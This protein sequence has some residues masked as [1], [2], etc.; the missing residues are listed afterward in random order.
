[1]EN[2]GIWN[3]PYNILETSTQ[4]V[5]MWSIQGSAEVQ[6]GVMWPLVPLFWSYFGV[7]PG[8]CS[9]HYYRCSGITK[10]LKNKCKS[11]KVFFKNFLKVLSKYF[12]HNIVLKQ[13]SCLSVSCFVYISGTVMLHNSSLFGGCLVE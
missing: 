7:V 13:L 4:M 12:F 2:A 8:Y 5:V 9:F 1:M 6:W 11:L 3:N 10:T